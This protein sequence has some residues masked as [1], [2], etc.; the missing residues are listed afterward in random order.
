VPAATVLSISLR[1]CPKFERATTELTG[2]DVVPVRAE[3]A[4]PVHKSRILNG[5]SA[6][7]APTSA[8]P[9]DFLP[10]DRLARPSATG[11]GVSGKNLRPFLGSAIAS[12]GTK[13]IAGAG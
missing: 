2:A 7:H 12:R 9:T 5:R 1:I 8:L 4:L 6:A 13:T 3:S 10:P 11:S